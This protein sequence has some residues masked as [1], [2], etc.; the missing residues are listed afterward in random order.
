MDGVVF[1]GDIVSASLG[2]VLQ[3]L[4]HN[5]KEGTLRVLGR[6]L[7]KSVY[8]SKKGVTLLNPNILDVQYFSDVVVSAGLAEEELVD[9]TVK[10]IKPDQVV[11]TAF[12]KAGVLDKHTVKRILALHIEE[13]IYSLFDLTI[14]QFEFYKCKDAESLRKK[15]NLPLIPI[16][17]LLIESAKRTDELK[18][19]EVGS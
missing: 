13:E 6:D 4:F 7:V 11:H 10:N 8:C 1:K 17:S 3:M 18:Y 9:K 15:N 2:E 12:I 5:E 19:I 14:G 16:E